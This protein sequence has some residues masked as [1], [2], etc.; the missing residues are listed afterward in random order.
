MRH[1]FFSPLVLNWCGPGPGSSP[2]RA[3]WLV[4]RPKLMTQKHQLH[5]SQHSS[6]LRGHE[7]LR[8]WR[9]YETLFCFVLLQCDCNDLVEIFTK[10]N[11][12]KQHSLVQDLVSEVTFRKVESMLQVYKCNLFVTIFIN[13]FELV[14]DIEVSKTSLFSKLKRFVVVSIW[15]LLSCIL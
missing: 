7:C 15:L 5:A 3:T 6:F 14:M 11:M 10:V 9:F 4:C 13:I 2:G 8:E 1:N 12:A